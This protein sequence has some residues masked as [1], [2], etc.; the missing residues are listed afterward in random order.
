MA[1]ALVY[2]EK[3]GLDS[4]VDIA[5]LTGA[6]VVAL[7]NDVA[8]LWSPN[9]QLAEDMIACGAKSGEKL[10]RMP[11]FDGYRDELKSKISDLRNIGAGRA[12]SSIT[13]ALFLN[14]FVSTDKWVHLDIASKQLDKNGLATAFGTKTLFNYIEQIA[15]FAASE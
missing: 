2:A 7:G 1:D 11:L 3:L 5:T 9:D 15:E 8:G 4:V 14:E 13:A 12:A 6:V 10:W